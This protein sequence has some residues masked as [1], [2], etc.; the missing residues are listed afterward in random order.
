MNKILYVLLIFRD[1][2]EEL[3]LLL[4]LL[5]STSKKHLQSSIKYVGVILA[6]ILVMS[7]E[8]TNVV[9]CKLKYS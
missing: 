5:K 7:A 3:K 6:Y 2:W 8:V 9:L 4:L 1:L